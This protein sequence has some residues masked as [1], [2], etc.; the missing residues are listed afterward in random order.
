MCGAISWWK[1]SLLTCSTCVGIRLNWLLNSTPDCVKET[2]KYIS[3][4]LLLAH[5]RCRF[6][7]PGSRWWRMDVSGRPWWRSACPPGW[8]A[9]AQPAPRAPSPRPRARPSSPDCHGDRGQ[10]AHLPG[11]I[12]RHGSNILIVIQCLLDLTL[13]LATELTYRQNAW[14]D[15]HCSYK[16]G[17]GRYIKH[18][19][20][21]KSTNYNRYSFFISQNYVVRY[22]VK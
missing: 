10:Y 17:K 9:P 5:R 13:M 19:I 22:A 16:C 7:G 20:C 2:C 14:I 15:V 12:T 11:T 21:V 6:R 18:R 4:V 8:S 1:Y 3:W